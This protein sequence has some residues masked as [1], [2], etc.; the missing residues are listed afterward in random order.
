MITFKT[1]QDNV[2]NPKEV[3]MKEEGLLYDVK[4]G[5][6]LHVYHDN[7]K[8]IV[9]KYACRHKHSMTTIVSAE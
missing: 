7:G 4:S 2:I 1:I 3:A 9:D 8:L 5:G 6:F